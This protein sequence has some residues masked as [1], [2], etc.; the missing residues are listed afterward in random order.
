MKEYFQQIV[1]G[2]DVKVVNFTYK[3]DEIVKLNRKEQKLMQMK[4]Y[5]EDY[6][7]EK[8]AELDIDEEQAEADEV[9]LEPPAR[10]QGLLCQKKKIMLCQIES[11]I[12]RVKTQSKKLE[13]NLGHGTEIDL[14]FGT[15]IIVFE[16][17]SDMVQTVMHFEHS[18]FWRVI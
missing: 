11:Q 14:Y 1:E 5:F 6:R 10:R 12:E 2:S 3:I 13:E 7:N 17:Q 8:L 18:F 4:I 15:A 16:R 9:D